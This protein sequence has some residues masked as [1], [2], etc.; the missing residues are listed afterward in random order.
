MRHLIRTNETSRGW[1]Y[2]GEFCLWTRTK[3]G[4][5]NF[6]SDSDARI[7]IDKLIAIEKQALEAVEREYKEGTK[8]RVYVT[9]ANRRLFLAE[10]AEIEEVEAEGSH[11]LQLSL[12]I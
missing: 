7:E 5:I 2:L 8:A 1:W 3:R 10:A 12:R 9:A 4:A 6:A 11:P